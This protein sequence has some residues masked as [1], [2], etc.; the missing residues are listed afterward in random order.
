MSKIYKSCSPKYTNEQVKN[1]CGVV[2]FVSYERLLKT[3]LYDAIRKKDD[4]Q[5]VGMVIDFDGITVYIEKQ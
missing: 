3:S 5:I 2:T 4:E 1:L